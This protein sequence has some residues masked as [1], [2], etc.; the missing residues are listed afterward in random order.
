MEIRVII[1][2]C[3]RGASRYVRSIS[4]INGLYRSSAVRRGGSFFV[5]SGQA[6]STAFLTVRHDTLYLRSSSRIFRPEPVVGCSGSNE[7]FFAFGQFSTRARA[8]QQS[9]G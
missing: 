3:L 1:W 8:E 5:G 2:R 6:E 4:S 7:V 9:I